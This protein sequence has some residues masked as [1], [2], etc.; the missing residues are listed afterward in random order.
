M[1]TNS[2]PAAN[3]FCLLPEAVGEA[4]STLV[5]S[6]FV[7]ASLLR[8]E[9]A[10][11]WQRSLSY[12]L[13]PLAIALPPHA[14]CPEAP[15][16][17]AMLVSAAKAHMRQLFEFLRGKGYIVMLFS[18]DGHI[19]SLLGDKDMISVA[20]ALNIN[21]G[22]DYSERLIGTTAPGICLV[23]RMPVQVY[24]QEHYS[25]WSQEWC[26]S[27]APIFNA[28]HDLLG[29][30]NAANTDIRRHPAEILNL[31]Q[32]AA[33]GIGAEFSCRYLRKE[34]RKVSSHLGAVADCASDPLIIFDKTDT[35]IHINRN[36]QQILGGN[37]HK[38]VGRPAHDLI[39]NYAAVKEGLNAGRE[40]AELH[41]SELSQAGA[42][43][44][45]LKALR[46]DSHET[47]GIVGILQKQQKSM[48]TPVPVRYGF[49]DFIFSSKPV[50]RLIEDARHVADTEHTILIQ[51]ESGT[52][53][54]VLSQAIH[55]SSS[56]RNKPFVVINCAALPRELIQSELFG[57]E[58]GSFTGAE[59][60]GKAGKFELADGG[61]IFLDEIGDMPL[62]AQ[63]NLLRVL[64]EKKIVRIGGVR[65]RE[66]NVRVI[67]ATNRELLQD[68][69]AGRFRSDLFY[70]LCVI[71]LRIPPL[72]D[73]REEIWTLME[74]FV[75]KASGGNAN[76]HKI[77]FSKQAKAAL[78]AY[79][80]PGNVRELE[81]AVICFLAKMRDGIVTLN[82][83][84][85]Q[86]TS[87]KEETPL[88]PVDDLRAAERRTIE[89]VMLECSGHI[90]NAAKLL[91]TSRSTLYRKLKIYRL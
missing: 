84:P 45:Q 71:N 37:A 46:T 61:T 11:S 34:Y 81:N 73:R 63:A 25:R 44:A 57:Y 22:A 89:K 68:V 62:E 13:D 85:P 78:N 30:I 23:R 12:A 2:S 14:D 69:A 40:W 3:D 58:S 29:A 76:L 42:L 8:D 80:W 39:A 54:E 59:K 27:A 88:K 31:V 77:R 86:V 53:K 56:R 32:L 83:L 72:R 70:R 79:A 48:R 6:R 49:R 36:A 50:A 16:R 26:S 90:S 67:A 28:R 5:S 18:A 51:G 43:D 74:Y 21:T 35:I 66:I 7:N 17:Q 87:A 91:G 41:F 64:Q 38:F 47:L 4:W 65:P 9:I 24:K 10:S 52:G 20:G 82:E 15:G 19:I 55:Q 75:D 60:G 1:L 33:N